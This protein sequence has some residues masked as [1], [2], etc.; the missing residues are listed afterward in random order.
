MGTHLAD[1]DTGYAKLDR[2]EPASPGKGELIGR[3]HFQMGK[4]ELKVSAPAKHR[5]G[6][7]IIIGHLKFGY[8][9]CVQKSKG[10]NVLGNVGDIGTT[11]RR[12]NR[13]K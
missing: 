4:Y 13:T 12:T 5:L 7:W 6:E 11:G 8:I 1:R 9:L 2:H 10:R 3:G